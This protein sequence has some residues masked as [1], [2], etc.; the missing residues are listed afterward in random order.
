MR[1]AHELGQCGCQRIPQRR[2]DIAVGADDEQAAVIQP[3]GDESKEQERRFVG[4]VQVVEHHDERAGFGG[5]CEEGTHRLEEAEAR[6]L[7]LEWRRLQE[8]REAVA[9]L[10]DEL[11]EIRRARCRAARAARRAPYRR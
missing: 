2:I 9:Q 8:V 1:L 4:C 3:A 11:G 5:A 6:T 7:P 10:G